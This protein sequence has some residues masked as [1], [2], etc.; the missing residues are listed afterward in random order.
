M[1]GCE[2][3][4]L[5]ETAETHAVGVGEASALRETQTPGYRRRGVGVQTKELLLAKIVS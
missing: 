4:K 3:F 2:R 5:V 1:A